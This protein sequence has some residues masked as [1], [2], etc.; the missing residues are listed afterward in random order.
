MIAT[1]K[2]CGSKECG[3]RKSHKENDFCQDGKC[4]WSAECRCVAESKRELLDDLLRKYLIVDRDEAADKIE[5]IY[6]EGV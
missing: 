5:E 3:H 4:R 1:H 2:D 6:K